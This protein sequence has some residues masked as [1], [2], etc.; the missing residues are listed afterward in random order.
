[1]SLSK[2]LSLGILVDRKNK[3]TQFVHFKG[4]VCN[5]SKDVCERKHLRRLQQREGRCETKLKSENQNGH[6]GGISRFFLT[7]E[8]CLQNSDEVTCFL[9]DGS[10][11]L[12]TLFY[13]MFF[14][15]LH[16]PGTMRDL[17]RQCDKGT[18]LARRCLLR[19]RP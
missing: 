16:G 12:L 11:R 13:L 3:N 5:I 9:Q 10:I 19:T 4:P 1:M 8:Q 2:R 17:K 7:R 14:L 18:E 15:F 6:Q